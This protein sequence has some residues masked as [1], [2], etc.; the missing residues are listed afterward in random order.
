MDEAEREWIV[1]A[2]AWASLRHWIYG[3]DAG[4]EARAWVNRMVDQR[5]QGRLLTAPIEA[6]EQELCGRLH[7]SGVL[8]GTGPGQTGLE[9]PEFGSVA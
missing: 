4:D 6:L 8:P 1:R 7:R 9:M 2:M 3:R 5:R